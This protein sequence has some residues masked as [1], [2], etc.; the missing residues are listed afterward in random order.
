MRNV[1]LRF[2][3]LTYRVFCSEPG[4]I[5]LLVEVIVTRFPDVQ[6]LL[7]SAVENSLNYSCWCLCP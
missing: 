6:K 2:D 5:P 4:E 7:S 1:L 3:G